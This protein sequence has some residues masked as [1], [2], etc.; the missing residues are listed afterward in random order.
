MR[1]RG[2]HEF[3]RYNDW[4]LVVRGSGDQTHGFHQWLFWNDGGVFP[5]PYFALDSSSE[6]SE[7]SLILE[8]RWGGYRPMV[9]GRAKGPLQGEW[10]S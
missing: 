3:K 10:R 4:R 1:S 2:P 8:A 6:F 7:S 9:S 5:T